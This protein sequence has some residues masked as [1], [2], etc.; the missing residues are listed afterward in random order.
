MTLQHPPETERFIL[1]QLAG[2]EGKRVLDVGSGKGLYGYLARAS[3]G[4]DRAFIVGVDVWGPYLTFCRSFGAYDA[5]I[6]ADATAPLPFCRDS[7]DVVLAC[8]VI[9]HLPA[10]AGEALLDQVEGIAREKVVV[11][12]PNGDHL[13]GPIDDVPTEA[14]QSVWRPTDLRKRGYQVRGMG[15]RIQL[16]LPRIDL[17]LWYLLTPLAVRFPRLGDSIIASKQVG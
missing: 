15:S 11:T 7:F 8:E 1:P 10:D 2:L 13:R 14:H 9:E 3:D 6:L 5:L 12:V 16:G 17:A 4:G